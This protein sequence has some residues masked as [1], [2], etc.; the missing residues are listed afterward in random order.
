[1]ATN[2]L[3]SKEATNKKSGNSHIAA[4]VGLSNKPLIK[5]LVLQQ[6]G[7]TVEVIVVIPGFPKHQR[8]VY[9]PMSK[10]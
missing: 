3:P 1:M 5:G 6:R 8:Y 7:H 4:A 10:Q 2:E 9:Y